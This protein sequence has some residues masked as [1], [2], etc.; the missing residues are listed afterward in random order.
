M[1]LIF[2]EPSG[3][4]GVSKGQ[5]GSLEPVHLK[6]FWQTKYFQVNTK[7]YWVPSE[8]GKKKCDAAGKLLFE[9][10]QRRSGF[11]AIM[12]RS[13]FGLLERN[14]SE[15]CHLN[16]EVS[17]NLINMEMKPPSGTGSVS[18]KTADVFFFTCVAVKTRLSFSIAATCRTVAV[19]YIIDCSLSS[20]PA[21]ALKKK[22]A[23]FRFLLIYVH[24]FMYLVI[25]WIRF[26]PQKCNPRCFRTI[27]FFFH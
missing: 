10:E 6:R 4:R 1:F 21:K 3:I 9:V 13:A 23:P 12:T 11:D 5:K 18:L 19:Q 24:A 26:V 17:I 25:D 8:G 27:F 22:K 15:L 20:P 14:E 2:G 7:I 16:H